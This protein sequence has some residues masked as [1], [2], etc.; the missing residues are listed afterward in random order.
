MRSISLAIVTAI[1]SS[2]NEKLKMVML[3]ADSAWKAAAANQAASM[4]TASVS[5]IA[6]SSAEASKRGGQGAS[7]Q[8][9]NRSGGQTKTGKLCHF[10]WKFGDSARKCSPDCTRWNEQN[11][12]RDAKVFQVEEALDG[13]DTNI[14]SEN[15]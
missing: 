14:G 13:E 10:H 12:V 3:V 5:A 1:T 4:T 11:H 7:R 2:L 8:R 15:C 6:G 9:G